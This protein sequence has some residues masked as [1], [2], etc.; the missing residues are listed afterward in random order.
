MAK[1]IFCL[2]GFVFLISGCV[3]AVG[4]VQTSQKNVIGNDVGAAAVE[5]LH[6]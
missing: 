5:V 2:Y 4:G 6:E 1:S 3:S